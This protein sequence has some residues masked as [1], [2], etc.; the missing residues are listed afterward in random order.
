MV[1]P[2]QP[3]KPNEYE[4]ETGQGDGQSEIDPGKVGNNTEVDLDRTHIEKYPNPGNDP[5]R[6]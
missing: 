1:N 4:T 2:D 5:Q 6:K 3:E